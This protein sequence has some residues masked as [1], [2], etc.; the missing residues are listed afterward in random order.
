[1]GSMKKSDWD[2][3]ERR[4][5]MPAMTSRALLILRPARAADA[6]ALVRLA[7]LDSSRPL[8]GTVLVAEQG[9]RLI[10]AVS[11]VDGRAVADPFEP[12]ADVVAMLRVRAEQM[13]PSEPPRHVFAGAL[14]LAWV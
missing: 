8:R 2:L 3:R 6:P 4:A 14:H 1:M 11:L 7:R 12:T 5:M 10:A 9:D 13:Q